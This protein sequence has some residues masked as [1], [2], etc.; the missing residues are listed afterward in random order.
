MH[1][2]VQPRLRRHLC[3]IG[4]AL[5]AMGASAAVVAAGYP[6]RPIELVVPTSPAGGTDLLARLFADAARKQLPQPFVI[7]NKPGAAGAIGMKNVLS[8]APDGYKVA[9][10]IAAWAILPSL[11]EANW[12]SSDFKYVA[13][14]NEDPAAITVRAEAPWKTIEEFL[15]DAK[16]RPGAI[17]IGNVGVGS[18]YHFAAAALEDK[19]G[20]KFSHIPFQGANPAVTALL[21][22]HIDA[23]AVSPA[24]V[25]GPVRAGKFRVLAVMSEKRIKGFEKVPTL[26]ERNIP[27]S[28]GTW[29]GLTV[30]KNTPESVVSILRDATRKAVADPEFQAGIEKANLGY[31][32]LDG[33]EFQ[34]FAATNFQYFKQL[35]GK[36]DLK[37]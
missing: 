7:V 6:E 5:L 23:V 11:G 21:G 32:Y 20:L 36:L 12:S 31:A 10:I 17:S 15:A 27:L 1:S 16:K 3:Q 19:T 33:P 29:R 30:P 28:I 22:G 9:M 4:L 35:A 25:S 13:R 24:E 26:M 2:Q 8:A 34:A 18:I 37:N 14:I